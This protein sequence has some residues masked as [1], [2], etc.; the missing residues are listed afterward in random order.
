VSAGSRLPQILQCHPN[1]RPLS[2]SPRLQ[3]TSRRRH[4]AS[5]AIRAAS[6]HHEPRSS[7]VCRRTIPGGGMY[8]SLANL[9][10][11]FPSSILVWP[12][13]G[14]Y[15]HRKEGDMKHIT[16]QTYVGSRRISLLYAAAN[17]SHPATRQSL[18]PMVRARARLS[19]RLGR[20][21][22]P[23]RATP[24]TSQRLWLAQP[25]TNSSCGIAA[26]LVEA[27]CVV[28][29]WLLRTSQ[30]KSNNRGMRGRRI[31]QPDALRFGHGDTT[32]I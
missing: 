11:E 30:S 12:S 24:R 8:K 29:R 13:C 14:G 31:Q 10:F 7:L 18:R 5:N 2:A 22:R 9:S 19:T 25:S 20:A 3:T 15:R 16:D 4:K 17:R 23:H 6:R 21:L 28:G 26:R 32:C 27:R 1:L